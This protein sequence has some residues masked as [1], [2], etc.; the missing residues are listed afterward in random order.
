MEVKDAVTN[1]QVAPTI[2][3]ALGLDPMTLQA[4]KAEGTKVLPVAGLTQ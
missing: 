2:V 3:M 4:V 1:Q